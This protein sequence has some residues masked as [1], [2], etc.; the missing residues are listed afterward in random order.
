M[1]GTG[2]TVTTW[3]PFWGPLDTFT[4]SCS[5]SDTDTEQSVEWVPAE[6]VGEEEWCRDEEGFCGHASWDE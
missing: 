1:S 2:D 6:S 5:H 3:R 4:D